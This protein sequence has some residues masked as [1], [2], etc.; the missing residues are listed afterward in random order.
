[1]IAFIRADA[2]ILVARQGHVGRGELRESMDRLT[3]V[4]GSRL[5]GLVMNMVHTPGWSGYDSRYGS[6]YY[7][8]LK[9]I[10]DKLAL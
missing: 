3:S 4:P 2:V 1:M 9:F 8:N 10:L 5:L 7:Y 6:Q